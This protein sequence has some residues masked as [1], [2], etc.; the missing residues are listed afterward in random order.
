LTFYVNG[1]I[2]INVGAK[3]MKSVYKGH[4]TVYHWG[5]SFFILLESK[6]I[7]QLFQCTLYVGAIPCGRPLKN[8][9][10]KSM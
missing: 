8:K 6:Q 10:S 4:K 3:I 2:I 7:F 1:A 5:M 9:I